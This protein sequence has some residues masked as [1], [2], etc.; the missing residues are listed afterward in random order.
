[1]TTGTKSPLVQGELA[2]AA[3]MSFQLAV[4]KCRAGYYIDMRA[5]D[6]LLA[7]YGG[8]HRPTSA[9]AHELDSKPCDPIEQ[10]LPVLD[11]GYRAAER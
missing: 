5:A 2:R 1:M 9:R 3:G 4:L 11:V 6:D 8:K 10:G 7:R